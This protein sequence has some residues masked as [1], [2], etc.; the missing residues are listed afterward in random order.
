MICTT[1]NQPGGNALCPDCCDWIEEWPRVVGTVEGTSSVYVI[2]E[3]EDGKLIC[4]CKGYQFRSK[5][6]HL[7]QFRKESEVVVRFN[8]VFKSKDKVWEVE[9]EEQDMKNLR[10]G[11]VTDK[12]EATRVYLE[13]LLGV[14]VSFEQVG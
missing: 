12:L 13:R 11:D 8:V 5:C 9:G 2:R 7:E 14:K 1:C 4:E 10:V 6:R 3:T